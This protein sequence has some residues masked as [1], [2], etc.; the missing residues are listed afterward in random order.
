MQRREL[1]L[2]VG[3]VTVIV[4]WLGS[5][6]LSRVVFGPIQSKRAELLKWKTLTAQKEDLLLHLAHAKK[7]H[8]EWRSRSL[9]PDL[10]KSK[11]R[12]DALNA[13][14]LYLG[15]LTDLAQ[16]CGFEDLKVSPD[17]R[18]LKGSVYISVMVKIEAGVRFEQLC[19]FLDRFYSTDLLHRVTSLRIQS[20]DSEG[21]ALFQITLEAEGLAL[22]DAPQRRSLFPQTH[23]TEELAAEGTTLKVDRSEGFPQQL[24]FRIRIQNEY[25]TVIAAEES[26][27]TVVRGIDR[28]P[29]G[30]HP[31]GTTIE[32]TP[33]STSIPSRTNEDFL[34][35]LSQNI[36]LKPAPPIEYQLKFGPLGEKNHLRGNKPFEFT[37]AAMGYDSTK[38]RP[39]FVLLGTPLKGMH[40][41]AATGKLT[42]KPEA[43]QPT[44]KYSVAF[45][46]RH[47]NAIGGKL[48][49][50]LTISLNDPNTPPMFSELTPPPVFLGQQW[51]FTPAAAD[52]E[53]ALNKLSWKLGGNPSAGWSINAAT[54]ELLWN[55]DKSTP[56]GPTVV[57]ITVTDDGMPP[58]STTLELTLEIQEDPATLTLLT[59]TFAKE[60]KWLAQFY[61][62]SKS[63]STELHE[64]DTF[65]VADVQGTI[66][67][68]SAKYL[69]F[70]SKNATRRLE[71]GRSLRQSTVENDE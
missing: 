4:I 9:P 55:P 28:T 25:L 1:L 24:G 3:L 58:Q 49:E 61:N 33:R 7:Q 26:T 17:R 11:Q 64:G 52:R 12:P 5:T 8:Q 68:I 27:W 53:T 56:L 44:G 37:I 45:E 66:L 22:L 20:R 21:T 13:Q 62:R 31:E 67:K 2:I 36:F 14:R 23:L 57:G 43:G 40:L 35:L 46:V 15:W 16:S 32:L 30:D 41:D 39:E 51:Q 42:W 59:T 63:K 70:R 50:S 29:A 10:V 19:N 47:P 60:G 18:T 69:V 6:G 54:G 48:S 34:E 38:G 65:A 71:V